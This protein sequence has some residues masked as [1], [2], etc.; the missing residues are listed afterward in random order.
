MVLYRRWPRLARRP[1]REGRK[2]RSGRPRSLRFLADFPDAL[3]A[4]AWHALRMNMRRRSVSDEVHG[5]RATGSL[6]AGDFEE[7]LDELEWTS[8]RY[9]V[10]FLLRFA[11]VAPS[12]AARL[13]FRLARRRFSGSARQGR[14]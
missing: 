5:L 14:R 9:F 10:G 1:S 6:V 8:A 7:A 3:A 2:S 4:L 12:V 11:P 13:A